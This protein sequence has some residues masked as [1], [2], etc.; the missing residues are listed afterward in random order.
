ML[1]FPMHTSIMWKTRLPSF[2]RVRGGR[3]E[4][5][6][7]A[8]FCPCLCDTLASPLFGP[9]RLL[10]CSDLASGAGSVGMLRLNGCLGPAHAAPH[11]SQIPSPSESVSPPLEET[12]LAP[13]SFRKPNGSISVSAIEKKSDLGAGAQLRDSRQAEFGP[14]QAY[15]NRLDRSSHG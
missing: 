1:G 15:K 13:A 9:R 6:D 3:T 8:K 4:V 5:D 11:S 10:R 14:S 2:A 12:D 7:P